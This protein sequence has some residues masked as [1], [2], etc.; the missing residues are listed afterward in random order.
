VTG[1]A[2]AAL[3]L[4]A[5]ALVA[6]ATTPAPVSKIV[7]GK[8]VLTRAIHPDA[9]EHVARAQLFQQEERWEQAIDEL[10]RALGYDRDSPEIHA[11]I[12]ELRLELGQD[13]AAAKAV[14]ASLALGE[15]VPGLIAQA[16][17][18]QHRHDPAGAVVSL[19]RAADVANF[20]E[21]GDV[22]TLAHLELADAQLETLDIAGA[23]QTLQNLA[24]D[25]PNSTL[26]RVRLAG[27]A[28]S[29]GAMGDVERRLREALAIEPNHVEAL[30]TLAWLATANGRLEDAEARFRDAL[31]RA[32]GALDVATAFARFLVLAGRTEEA[33]QIADDVSTND[34]ET[35]ME[36]IELNRAAHRAERALSLARERRARSEINEDLAARLDMV[37][38]DMLADK[39]PAEALTLLRRVPKSAPAFTSAR[40]RA[41]ELLQ[42]IGQPSEAR[43]LLTEIEADPPSDALRDDIAVAQ[44][45]LDEKINLPK[46]ALARLGAAV[47]KRPRSARL[48]LA[49]AGLLE[50]QGRVPEALAEAEA[51]LKDDPGNAEVLNFWGFLAADHHIE[52]PRAQLRIQAALAFDPG[53]GAILDSLGWA[54]L[55][56]GTLDRAALYLNQAGHLEPE[57]PEILSHLAIL[58]ERRGQAT[59]ALAYVHKALGHTPEPALRGRLE[60][61]QLRLQQNSAG[62]GKNAERPNP[63]KGTQK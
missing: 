47:A 7:A 28:W 31:E 4:L 55:Q 3:V 12:A 41:A 34:D 19:R 38:A 54:H 8:V 36:R 2:W 45:L 46:E 6:C 26:A 9:Y 43:K 52:L 61:Q 15:T 11:Q 53:S 16:H 57:D 32:E 56:A 42:K 58:A 10:E 63:G 51:L 23:R 62:A 60:S 13:D 40:L 14:E 50:R 37:M 22:A 5:G 35:L 33:G 20:A 44:A 30:L 29:L 27:V 25:E 17:V 48:R 21:A 1:R 24:D 39:S 18:R 49:R 59:A